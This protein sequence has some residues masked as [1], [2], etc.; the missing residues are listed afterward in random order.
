MQHWLA[1][2]R[3]QLASKSIL[4]PRLEASEHNHHAA[5]PWLLGFDD[6]FEFP[7]LARVVGGPTEKVASRSQKHWRSIRKQSAQLTA[8]NCIISS[9][10]MWRFWDDRTMGRIAGKLRAAFDQV[11]LVGYV[12]S[13]AE[14]FSSRCRQSIRSKGIISL[15]KPGFEDQDG[16][17]GVGQ[18]WQ[19]SQVGKL[20]LYAY[21]TK[22]LPEGDI[23]THFVQNHVPEATDLI[24]TPAKRYNTALSAEALA[25]LQ[26]F[27][28][29]KKSRI[30]PNKVPGFLHK[31]RNAVRDVDRTL[32]SF[33]KAQLHPNVAR[34]I[35]A[36]VPSLI[37][38]RDT[39]G[40]HFSDV[41]YDLVGTV[42]DRGLTENTL[43]GDIFVL[44]HERLDA[45]RE[46]VHVFLHS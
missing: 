7:N 24:A 41:D 18:K 26:E 13:P 34:L 22:Q 35:N 16:S 3:D 30:S 19:S 2:N 17:F 45:L 21:E 29:A 14:A 42:D 15:P 5:M 4:Y 9:E 37:A 23:A 12:R 25:L 11:N 40:V 20:H 38:L 36:S 43:V 46:A 44:D 33:Q 10:A 28:A 27:I 1:E 39:Y 6:F 31:F 8:A 32:D